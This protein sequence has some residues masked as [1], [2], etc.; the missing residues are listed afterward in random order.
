MTPLSLNDLQKLLAPF[1]KEKGVIKAVL[2]GSAARG[3][4][5]KKSD[6]DFMIIK[7]TEKRFF[8]R[9]EEFDEIHNII[10]NR[11]VDLL[12]YT[13]EELKNISHRPFIKK[14]L[15]EGKLIYEC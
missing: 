7:Q 2:F 8:K 10:K 5:T 9:F 11:A 6:L 13:P 4:E 1:F 14:I 15:E 3:S 12:I